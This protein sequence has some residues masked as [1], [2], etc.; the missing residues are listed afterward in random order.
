M[1]AALLLLLQTT[2]SLPAQ[3]VPAQQPAEAP[4]DLAAS[5]QEMQQRIEKLEQTNQQLLKQLEEAK[6]DASEQVDES[7]Q[8]ANYQPGEDPSGVTSTVPDHIRRAVEDYLKKK[9]DSGKLSGDYK[10][11][12]NKPI[13]F[14]KYDNGWL[15]ES[16]DRAFTIRCGV[17]CQLDM[18]FL[19]G[20]DAVEY[21]PGGVGDITNG[22]NIRRGR[23]DARGTIYENFE[24]M[25]QYDFNLAAAVRTSPTQ[26]NIFN[27]PQPT[28]VWGMITHLPLVRNIRIGNQKPLWS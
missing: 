4:A 11:V 8:P 25:V 26:V 18:A 2:G 3:T 17:E 22:V 7:I 1:T 24:Y 9:D 21:G 23:L 13:M 28:E 14:G 15:L 6:P 12:G 20:S 19:T 5:V 16:P 27:S 10:E